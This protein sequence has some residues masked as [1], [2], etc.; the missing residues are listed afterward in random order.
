ML[1]SSKGE[2]SDK[3]THVSFSKDLLFR[4]GV[5]LMESKTFLLRFNSSKKR[6]S[7]FFLLK[8]DTAK[9]RKQILS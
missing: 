3:D 6:E 9:K 5:A 1:Y 8:V 7:K 4:E 2:P